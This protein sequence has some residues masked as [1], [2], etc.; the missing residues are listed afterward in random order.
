MQPTKI[1]NFFY[2]R[3]TWFRHLKLGNTRTFMNVRKVGSRTCRST[4]NVKRWTCRVVSRNG[5]L[6]LEKRARFCLHF[7]WIYGVIIK[8]CRC[9]LTINRFFFYE[10][11]SGLDIWTDHLNYR[12]TLK[13]LKNW[14]Q[15]ARTCRSSIIF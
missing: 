11:L 6:K 7:V 2:P 1:K 8:C 13:S 15:R 12:L 3:K 4:S 9:T 14:S 5:N 10:I